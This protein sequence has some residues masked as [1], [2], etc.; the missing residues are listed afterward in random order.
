M[1]TNEY[2]NP[3]NLEGEFIAEGDEEGGDP[4]VTMGTGRRKRRSTVKRTLRNKRQET[5]TE[6]GLSENITLVSTQELMHTT[7]TIISL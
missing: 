3:L 7:V 5:P 1:C 4:T 2:I 6:Q